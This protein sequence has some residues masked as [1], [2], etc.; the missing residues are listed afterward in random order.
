MGA[1]GAA[2]LLLPQCQLGDKQQSGLS[3][4]TPSVLHRP[5][6]S[7]QNMVTASLPPFKCCIR[8][9]LWPTVTLH[10]QRRESLGSQ[11]QLT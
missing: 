1:E 2:G 4:T 5:A 7:K 3:A 10:F 11:C 8:C 9:L 6:R